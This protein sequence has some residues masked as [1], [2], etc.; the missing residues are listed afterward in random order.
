M[1]T[2]ARAYS[3]SQWSPLK[4]ITLVTVVITLGLLIS[5]AP[6]VFML[7]FMGILAAILLNFLS[8]LLSKHTPLSHGW[9]LAVVLL[10]ILILVAS[11][12]GL[13]GARVASETDN[14]TQNLRGA[15]K[16]LEQRAGKYEWSR[17]LISQPS[18]PSLNSIP[19]K[20]VGRITGVF[21]TT[22]GVLSSA[23]LVVF[24][25]IFTAADPG[26]YRRGILR[27]V[28]LDHRDRARKILDDA[29]FALRWWVIGQM[30]SMTVVGVA[31]AIGLWM[32]GIP[33]F[34]TLGI[35]AGV[36]T[37]VP[38]F[39]PIISAIPAILLGLSN[40]LLTGVY[41]L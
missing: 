9:A 27:L 2:E 18:W 35:L 3:Y 38:N 39:G 24:V 30:F 29:G 32:L 14:L 36:L 19:T 6:D 7:T 28:P 16:Q 10:A 33:F 8:E 40:G 4:I 5:F 31:T 1:E 41:V 12:I 17:Q 22:F 11:F 15:W 21:T 26:L 23:L 37:F 20:L 13:A 25:A 34:V